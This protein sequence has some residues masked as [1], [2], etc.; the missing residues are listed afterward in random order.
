M[1]RW[2]KYLLVAFRLFRSQ[3]RLSPF[4]NGESQIT[5]SKEQMT[6]IKCQYDN[7]KVLAQCL[8]T[9]LLN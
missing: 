9:Q 6:G 2:I 3:Q 8:L 1:L 7:D 5:I 4:H